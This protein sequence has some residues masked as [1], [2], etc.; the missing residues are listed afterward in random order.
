MSDSITID[1]DA[2]AH[3]MLV[4]MHPEV[5]E[6]E[7]ILARVTAGTSTAQDANDLR[8]LLEALSRAA[9][10]APVSADNAA[11]RERVAMLE[12]SLVAVSQYRDREVLP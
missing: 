10:A 12:T 6:I 1:G 4:R 11:L 9:D 3:A 2:F 7:A 8:V 5:I